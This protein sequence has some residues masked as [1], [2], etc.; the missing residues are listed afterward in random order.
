MAWFIVEHWKSKSS[1]FRESPFTSGIWISK[2]FVTDLLFLESMVILI[3]FPGVL[4]EEVDFGV[5]YCW[6]L[7]VQIIVSRLIWILMWFVNDLLL[8]A[9]RINGDFDL[10]SHL[11][12]RRGRFLNIGSPNHQFL[13]KV[14]L[15]QGFEYQSHL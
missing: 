10:I 15:L 2:P 4:I 7:E 11:S 9:F 8:T 12:D 1:V 3:W 6:A 13:E 14:R 5:I